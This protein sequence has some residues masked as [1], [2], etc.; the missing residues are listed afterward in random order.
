MLFYYLIKCKKISHIKP[1]Q[2]GAISIQTKAIKG[3]TLILEKF[4][5]KNYQIQSS[6]EV[7]ILIINFHSD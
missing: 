3:K 1:T 2:E 4:R 6:Y 5:K 7:E